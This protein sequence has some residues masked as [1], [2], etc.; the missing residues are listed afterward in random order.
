[1]T[2]DVARD[3]WGIPIPHRWKDTFCLDCE[4]D[5]SWCDYPPHR[6]EDSMSKQSDTVTE[7]IDGR[8]DV[9]GDP[10]VE[11]ERHAQAWS[12][13]FG[14]EVRPDQVALA[15]IMYKV[16]RANRTPDYSDNSD[17]I[18]GYLDIFRKIVGDDMVHAR[19]VGEYLLLKERRDNP[20]QLANWGIDD[21]V[22]QSQRPDACKGDQ[23]LPGLEHD[24]R[25]DGWGGT[26]E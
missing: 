7:V 8:Q 4:T 20:R 17:D 3:P 11:F 22:R 21:I 18:E 1:M 15:L 5:Q 14:V 16:V 25:R 13:I 9:Y 12:A 2:T 19:S 6:E 26:G 23:P 24:V 10:A